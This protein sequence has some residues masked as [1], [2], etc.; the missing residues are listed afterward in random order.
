MTPDIASFSLTADMA[1][2]SDGPPP[3][4][5]EGSTSER[6]G[7]RWSVGRVEPSARAEVS[8]ATTP[9]AAFQEWHR[10]VW[11]FLYRLGV[12]REV[13][14]D[15]TQEVFTEVCRRWSSFKGLSTRRTWVLGFVPRIAG[16]YR[17]RSASASALE[18]PSSDA[19]HHAAEAPAGNPEDDP[20][21]AAARREA[22]AVVQAFLDRLSA[23]DRALFV[24][25]ELEEARIVD[26]AAILDM[27][28]RHAYR[29]LERIRHDFEATVLRH[30]ARDRWRLP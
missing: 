28:M 15:A 1:L 6:S 26:V 10:V 30:Q 12:P 29:S 23:R 22:T 8:D 2:A 19:E 13:L 20:F 11:R 9:E 14:E 25:V 5:S 3:A 7:V 17:R 27:N 4:R 21:E 16:K 24:M 18:L